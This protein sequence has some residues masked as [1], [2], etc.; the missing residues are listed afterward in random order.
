M[1]RLRVGGIGSPVLAATLALSFLAGAAAPDSAQ[2]RT[3]CAPAEE[4]RTFLDSFSDDAGF[5]RMRVKFPYSSLRLDSTGGEPREIREKISRSKLST[6]HVL[7]PTTADRAKNGLVYD[8]S[9][10]DNGMKVHLHKPDT[11]WSVFYFFRRENGCWY[12]TGVEDWS[13]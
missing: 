2:A 12:L 7:F 9:V 13:L 1:T 4:F 5:Q 10:A 8:S 6:G 11:D 3:S